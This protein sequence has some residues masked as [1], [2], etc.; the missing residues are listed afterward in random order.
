MVPEEALWWGPL[1][2]LG[3]A[4][5]GSLTPSLSACRIK[6]SEVFSRTS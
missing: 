1:M 4:L 3:T 2:G 5:A 6:V